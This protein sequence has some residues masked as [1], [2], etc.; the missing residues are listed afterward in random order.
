[1]LVLIA[2][3]QPFGP[4]AAPDRRGAVDGELVSP[5]VLEC[6]DSRC[7]TCNRS[8][9]GL[10]S[11]GVATT[12]VVVDRPGVDEV[13]LRSRIHDWLDGLGAVDRIVQAVEA[14][15]YAADGE[16]FAD[17]VAAVAELVD[18]HMIEI[19]T[20]CATFPVGTVVSRLGP[21]VAPD[22]F[23]MVA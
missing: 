5:V 12:A 19:Q 6:A 11:D 22:R 18:A 21:L 13:A 1:M 14:G 7:D 8:W 3:D 17:P 16:A 23:D 10:V 4:G 9:V 15:H 2:T 20:I